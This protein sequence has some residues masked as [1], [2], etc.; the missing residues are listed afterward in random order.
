MRRKKYRVA[1][2]GKDMM[3]SFDFADSYTSTGAIKILK[4]RYPEWRDLDIIVFCIH[5]NGD[6]E[7]L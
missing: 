3:L 7:R 1:V 4:K 6:L 2:Y 5:V